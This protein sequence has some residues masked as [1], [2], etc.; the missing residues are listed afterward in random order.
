MS[1][2]SKPSNKYSDQSILMACLPFILIEAKARFES[3]VPRYYIRSADTQHSEPPA[4]RMD[5]P[6]DHDLRS[7]LK[8]NNIDLASVVPKIEFYKIY[9]DKSG[10]MRE[11]YIPYAYDARKYAE[12]IYGNREQRG[13]DVG[14]RSVS[15]VYDE[16]N[17]SVAESLLGCTV[18]FVFANAE[19]L[20]TKR[21]AGFRFAE[22]FSFP[23]T[24]SSEI[25]DKGKYDIVLRVGYQLDGVTD[26]LSADVTN[27]LK[28]Q[29]RLIELT[30]VD[31]DI[32][33][34][35]NGMLNASVQYRSSNLNFFSAKKNEIFGA[36]AL[37]KVSPPAPQAVAAGQAETTKTDDELTLGEILD[38][39]EKAPEEIKPAV[40]L[41]ALYSRLQEY[42]AENCMIHKLDASIADLV[43]EGKYYFSK[44]P[45]KSTGFSNNLKDEMAGQMVQA[46]SPTAD[47]K[48]MLQRFSN[49]DYEGKRTVTYFYFGDLI[50]ALFATNLDLVGEMKKRKF[51][52]LLDNVGYQFIKGKPIS[53]FNVAKLPIAQSVFNEWFSKN[54][55]G[56]EKKIVS[57]MSFLKLYIMNFA[58][59]LLRVRTKDQI[60]TDY[61]PN[62]VR[63]LISV[64][65]RIPL[66]QVAVIGGIANP[67]GGVT[68]LKPMK[69]KSFYGKSAQDS[70]YE[71]YTI[72]DETY[73][74][75]RLS[76]VMINVDE[77]DR[78][79]FNLVSGIPHFYIGA[80]KGLLKEFSFQ[81]SSLGEE[82]TVIRNLEPGNPYQE[83]WTIFD[84]SATFIGNN[85]MAVGKNIYMDPSI[86]GLGSPLKKGT[87]ANIMGLGGYYMI[88]RVEHNY[89][90]KWTTSVTGMCIVPSN[91]KASHNSKDAVFT[92]F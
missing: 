19:A 48:E 17:P 11:V 68:D 1:S 16:Q 66:Q 80:D 49:K 34:S 2:K 78:Y 9:R 87:V 4:V 35:P 81:K 25:V 6:E 76:E 74:N 10:N 28:K 65:K 61:T 5:M 42:M 38:P 29:D 83:L 77:S 67:G 79:F 37:T 41:Q 60:G 88:T 73:Y 26:T 44:N 84:I 47:V 7:I 63:R 30:M 13:D 55:M 32:T 69:G 15:F 39:T 58:L 52:I 62:L 86:T 31:Y 70:Y 57:L 51:H 40:D 71:Y 24:K 50:D 46:G 56:K 33:F 92:Y 53:V 54:I 12:N 72:Y 45:C 18:D 23:N 27:A 20:V 75:D 64:P 22:L 82:I 91:Q 85:L 36:K 43:A 90:P 3:S 21:N 14:I 59:G 89:Y 8:V